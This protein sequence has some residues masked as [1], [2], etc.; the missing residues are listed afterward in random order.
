M[1]APV[2][3]LKTDRQAPD[4]HLAANA[5]RATGTESERA[6]LKAVFALLVERAGGV[7]PCGA[8]LGISHQRVSQLQS[9]DHK[10]VPNLLLHITPL[11]AFCGEP[12]VTSH[13]ARK[14]TGGSAGDP[15]EEVMEAIEAIVDAGKTIRTE[16]CTRARR[17]AL[18]NAKRQLDDVF[19]SL[20]IETA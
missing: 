9:L 1:S 6:E 19:D 4:S 18:L 17:A 16:R 20:G 11:E 14:V 3:T 5:D 10:D 7:V 12:V 15:I 2:H 8:R 13:Y